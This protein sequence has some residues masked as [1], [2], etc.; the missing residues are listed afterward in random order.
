M[1]ATPKSLHENTVGGGPF[2]NGYTRAHK[3]A[4]DQHRDSQD[5]RHGE[6]V[7]N[8]C[9][10]PYSAAIHKGKNKNHGH[11]YNLCGD[12]RERDEVPNIDREGDSKRR[13]TSRAN[14]KQK[15]PSEKKRRKLSPTFS[16]VDVLPA[17]RRIH[18]TEFG[19]RERSEI[20]EQ[21]CED[22]HGGDQDRVWQRARYTT[23]HQE[24]SRTH[25]GSAD[26]H[27]GVEQAELTWKIARG[28]SHGC[29]SYYVGSGTAPSSLAVSGDIES[30]AGIH[31]FSP[32]SEAPQW[33][34]LMDQG[35][36]PRTFIVVQGSR[37]TARESRS[38]GAQ[39]RCTMSLG[40]M[41]GSGMWAPLLPT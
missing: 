12:R 10:Q 11:G 38:V 7:L 24:D 3:G 2:E 31:Q 27:G 39:T 34:G 4:S 40:F 21:A 37:F 41:I 35:A 14:H 5:F 26:N 15:C 16:E 29:Q 13:R 8:G 1:V 32:P 23:R 19:E 25:Y 20:G 6:Y 30:I 36:D 22:P 18:S 9:P 17:A 28:G 33:R